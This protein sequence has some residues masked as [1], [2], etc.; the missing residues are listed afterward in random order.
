MYDYEDEKLEQR[1]CILEETIDLL[2]QVK[3]S[4]SGKTP[5]ALA[6]DPDGTLVLTGAG[7]KYKIALT[8]V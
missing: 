2:E 1:M 5:F 3:V 7:K 8:E 6:Y 4:N